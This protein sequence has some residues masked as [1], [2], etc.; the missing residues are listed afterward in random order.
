MRA[1]LAS[2]V[3]PSL[4]VKGSITARPETASCID[5]TY[6]LF[7]TISD[8]VQLDVI[9]VILHLSL[10]QDADLEH[11]R[12]RHPET[13]EFSHHAQRCYSQ[14]AGAYCKLS[15]A[16]SPPSPSDFLNFT[17]LFHCIQLGSIAKVGIDAASP[18][19]LSEKSDFQF[20]INTRLGLC[21]I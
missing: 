16:P 21:S 4:H 10:V 1:Q 13:C 20:L 15:L 19:F 12:L 7:Q 2:E 5:L 3:G 14:C 8:L 17:L 18:F 6:S 11:V 9:R